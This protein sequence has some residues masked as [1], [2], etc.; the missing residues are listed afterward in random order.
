MAVRIIDPAPASPTASGRVRII[1]PAPAVKG[2]G[3]LA[4]PFDL[5][6]GQPRASIPRGVYYKDPQGNIRR[7]DNGDRGNPIVQRR[8]SA[9]GDIARSTGAGVLQG[10]DQ[11]VGFLGDVRNQLGMLTGGGALEAARRS[12]NAL[13]SNFADA[14][15]GAQELTSQVG[16]MF[17]PVLLAS[18]FAPTSQRI[19]T[20]RQAVTGQDYVPQTEAGRMGRAVGRMAPNA[21]IPGSAPA[22]V[23]NVVLPGLAGEGARYA[24]E[25]GG[26]GQRG[27]AFA[28]M[29]GQLA[30]GVAA[31]VRFK[32]KPPRTPAPAAPTVDRTIP[33]VD[34]LQ[35]ETT[36][37]YQAADRAG[38]QY[39]PKAF[40]SMVDAIAA[41]AGAS[42]ISGIRHPKAADMIAEMQKMKDAG[43]SPTLTEL[44]QLRQVIRRDVASAADAAEAGFGQRMIRQ[45]DE[46]IANAGPDAVSAGSAQDAAGL[47]TNA[48][49]ANTKLRKVEAVTDAVESATTRAGSTGSG[50]NA[51]NAIRQNLRRVME[52]TGNLT[53]QERAAM[54]EIVMGSPAQNAL[55]QVGKL[56]PSGNGLMAAGNLASA[57]SFGPLGAVPGTLGLFA[58]WG[59]DAMTKQKVSSLIELMASGGERAGPAAQQLSVMAARDPVLKQILDAVTVQL[60]STSPTAAALPVATGATGLSASM[61]GQEQERR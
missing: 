20:E 3:T 39:T 24:A 21:L 7:N 35:G 40:A 11:V 60:T 41:D 15:I 61:A 22:R 46:F 1:D 25:R 6:G 36:A 19:A 8:A 14:A 54:R 32:P 34:R 45:V 16:Q 26:L 57:A 17:N 59:A 43:Y 30:G 44:D 37:A 51:N 53:P 38:V 50:G 10:S 27:Q 4:K 47:I 13:L 48:R 58:K 9:G 12:P 55:R 18:R 42:R 23:A 29:A 31:G 5:S 33:V 52:S 56:S 28:E 2:E 49:Q